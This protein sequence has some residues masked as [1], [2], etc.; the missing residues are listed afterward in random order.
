MKRLVTK[1]KFTI[2]TLTHVAASRRAHSELVKPRAETTEVKRQPDAIR[3]RTERP[4]KEWNMAQLLTLQVLVDD[5]ADFGGAA[6][7]IAALLKKMSPEVC[8][9]PIIDYRLIGAARATPKEIEEALKSGSYRAGDVFAAITSA[10]VT[11]HASAILNPGKATVVTGIDEAAQMSNFLNA[12]MQSAGSALC[13]SIETRVDMPRAILLKGQAGIADH[14][15]RTLS[16][17]RP[18][19][20]GPL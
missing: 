1:G 17:H 13:M 12:T 18:E 5:N 14:V 11:E 3:S 6:E 16:V 20:S 2:G 9:G 8:G 10:T 15:A 4:K 19:P 7:T